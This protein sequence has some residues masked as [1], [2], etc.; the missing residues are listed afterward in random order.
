MQGSVSFQQMMV[1]EGQSER[2]NLLI[3]YEDRTVSEVTLELEK[4][5]NECHCRLSIFVL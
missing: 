3:N 1:S 4:L 5:S 2:T